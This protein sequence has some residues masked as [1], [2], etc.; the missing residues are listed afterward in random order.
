MIAVKAYYDGYAF[1]PAG[2]VAA[3]INQEAIIT[4]LDSEVLNNSR[5]DWLLSFV[6]KIPHG[7]FLEMEKA[8]EETEKVDPNDW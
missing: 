2:P 1:V 8:L 7:D 3:E 5:K 4:L 6:G